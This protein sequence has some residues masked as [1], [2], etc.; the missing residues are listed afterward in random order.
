M[1]VPKHIQWHVIYKLIFYVFNE[2]DKF[3]ITSAKYLITAR[4]M[5]WLLQIIFMTKHKHMRE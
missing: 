4:K 5:N 3:L 1:I 2:L